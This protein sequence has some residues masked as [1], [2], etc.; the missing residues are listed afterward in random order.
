MIYNNLLFFLVVIFVFSTDTPPQEPWLSSFV[1]LPLFFLVLYVFSRI[2]G[3]VYGRS[4]TAASAGYFAA[5]KKLSVLAVIL[6]TFTVYVLD[7]KYYL[8]ALSL[9][10]SLPVLENIAGLAVFFLLLSI[11][12]LHGRTVYQV[13]FQ[14]RYTGSGF[15]ISNIKAN[16]PI[17]LPWLVL[18]FVFDL[19]T[20]LPFPGFQKILNAPWGDLILFGVFVVFLSLFFPPLVRRLWNCKPM[21]AGPMRRKIE[22]FCRQQGFSS[23]I[24]YWP[25]FEGQVLTAGIMGIVP[26]FR[27]LLV[28]PALLA[29]LG[30]EELDSVLA[31]EIGHVKKMHLVLYIVL[32]LGFSILAGAVIE[33]LPYLILGNDFFYRLLGWLHTSPDTL[34]AVL[35]VAPLLIFMVIYFR[36]I[37]GY[38]IRN[39]ERQAD[40]YVF[41]AQGTSH[42]LV[43]S[44]EK[45]AVLSGNI[46]D[47]K[48]WHHFGIG[49][50][51]DFLEKCE[52][53][54]AIIRRHDQK[55]YLSLAGYFI[56]IAAI[57]F[58]LQQV[59]LDKLAA[60][61]E[62][63]YTEAVLQQKLRQEPGNSLWLLLLGDLMQGREME[64]KAV[65][66]YE[67]AL[68]LAPM[69]AEV[70]NNLA[71]MLLTAK[72]GSLRDPARALTLARSAAL[73]K[74]EG[75]ILDTLAMAFWANGLVQEAMAA[76]VKAARVDPSNRKYY[77]TQLEKFK[78]ESWGRPEN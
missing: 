24:L 61:Y 58:G 44:F 76:E 43:S 14:C 8:Q 72:D 69:S 62:V 6:F 26:R 47:Q 52:H 7:L 78:R 27:Y 21:P 9:G 49:E 54:R 65:D 73:L 23:E 30:D 19:L 50:R 57:V 60:G 25:L 37:F 5:E 29:A 31:H 48:S 70:N 22:D 18:S 32:F 39:F 4:G 34:L 66:A 36:F 67:Q 28:T 3:K 11:M 38:F 53:N 74:E 40:L 51:V 42:P 41:K 10:G 45:I 20:A 33:P 55:V 16:M 56:F 12:W 2:A 13:L 15:V 71:W 17:V 77:Q 64:K 35:G 1:A 46:R 68:A 63:K 75:Y 59:D